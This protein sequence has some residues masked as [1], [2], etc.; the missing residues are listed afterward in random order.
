MDRPIR[1]LVKLAAS[2]LICVA[3]ISSLAACGRGGAGAYPDAARK[4]APDLIAGDVEDWQIYATGAQVCSLLDK[5]VSVNQLTQNPDP[6]KVAQ[7]REFV[8]LTQQ[9][10]CP[11]DD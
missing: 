6:D 11:E 2:S 1:R 9:G 7:L 3:V 4:A 8:E 10:L 5:G